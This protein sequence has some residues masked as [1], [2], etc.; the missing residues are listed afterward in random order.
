M[1]ISKNT[2]CNN[3]FDKKEIRKLIN[4]FISN[5]GPIRSLKLLENLKII[6]FK[7]AT[8][9]G[10]SIGLSDLIIPKEKKE[11]LRNTKEKLRYIKKKYTEGTLNNMEYQEQTNMRWNQ[12]NEIL[13]EEIIKNFKEKDP[14]NSLYIMVISGARGNLSQIRQLIGM[15]GLIAD[16]EGRIINNPVINN[17]KEGLNMPEY[18][19]SCYGARKGLIDTALKTAKSGYLTRRLIYA[20]Q[21]QVIKQPDCKTKK[22]LLLLNNRNTKKYYKL[23]IEKITGRIL[24]RK[25]NLN[26]K[27]I[28]SGQD[29][30]KYLAKK[31]LIVKKIFIRT[32]LLC[33]LNI[34]ICQ[35]CYGWNLGNGRLVE[36]G[37]SV[38]IIAAQ[39]ISEPGTQLTM[40]TFHTGGAFTDTISKTITSNIKGKIIYDSKKN[41]IEIETINKEKAFFTTKEKKL[42]IIKN[43]I[44]KE[45]ITL[46]RY[47]II[48][49]K[50]KENIFKKQ[51]IAE[52]SSLGNFNFLTKKKTLNNQQNKKTQLEA[53]M[54]GKI[55][56][57]QYDKNNKKD[58]KLIILNGNI[59]NFK[60]LRKNLLYKRDYTI[61]LKKKIN[62]KNYIKILSEERTKINSTP[63]IKN[64]IC[65]FIYNKYPNKKYTYPIKYK[66]EKKILTTK[67]KARI[68]LKSRLNTNV[69]LIKKNK[70][71]KTLDKKIWP[72]FLE[73]TN[74]KGKL[75]IQKQNTYYIFKNYKIKIKTN[76]LIKKGTIILNYTHKTKKIKD[77]TEGLPKI[78]EI[79]E[80]RI[81]PTTRK[82]ENI[83]KLEK[84]YKKYNNY[85]SE[86][87][88][89]SV[90]KTTFKI[91]KALIKK[92][93]SIYS[94]QQIF[95]S[96][97]HFEIIIKEMTSKVIIIENADSNFI[98]GEIIDKKKIEKINKK[99]KEKIIYK[100]TIIGIKKIPS[101]SP[102]FISACSFESTTKILS[103]SAIK[104]KIDWLQGIKENIILGNLI[105]IGTGY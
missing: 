99:N 28:N 73:E 27:T 13:K 11:L 94:A 69:K 58:K 15:R 24:S 71:L 66:A 49:T 18:F 33:N 35:M 80:N 89:I 31:I 75:S 53:D 48:F 19:T 86:N 93:Q 100:P 46:P 5:Y 79:L 17:L 103:D 96:D 4:W 82:K 67:N 59:L 39:S 23:N 14:L 105:P 88:T 3:L 102:S 26:N 72:S 22:S 7:I 6:G 78:E 76:S 101:Y 1:K 41:G 12:M 2:V 98:C 83:Y 62:R 60:K 47:S 10:I 16:N 42:L 29:I 30:C 36:L 64:K 70:G 37:E 61:Y 8:Q 68:N 9:S 65:T 52:K 90:N 77:I 38:G 57:I 20:V 84:L 34:G 87:I 95:L 91:Q 21:N 81:R 55:E 43:S 74:K 56:V 44:V 85:Y 50:N 63:T 32:P 97:K 40:R 25:V 45:V 92:L 51:I 104:G 54:S